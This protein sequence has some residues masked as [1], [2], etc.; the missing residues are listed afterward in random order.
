MK[1]SDELYKLI[2]EHEILTTQ[3]SSGMIKAGAARMAEERATFQN[4]GWSPPDD[5]FLCGA[6]WEAMVFHVI[7]RGLNKRK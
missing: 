2:A 4:N 1:L 5:D 3:A 6:V 7:N